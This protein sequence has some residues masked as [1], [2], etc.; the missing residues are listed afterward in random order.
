MNKS[1]VV[2]SSTFMIS[3]W[4]GGQKFIKILFGGLHKK[5]QAPLNS[6]HCF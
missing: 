5:E 2:Q 1:L 4:G 3:L 6:D